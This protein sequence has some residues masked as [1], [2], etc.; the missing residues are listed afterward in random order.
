MPSASVKNPNC[1]SRNRQRALRSKARKHT[2]Q[3]A[4]SARLPD[5]VAKADTKRGARTGLLPT[6]GP[7][8]PLSSKKARK[9]EKQMA[10]AIRRKREEEERQSQVEMKDAEEKSSKKQLKTERNAAVEA[11]EKMEIS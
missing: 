6:S 1:I 8:K 5:R 4:A 3:A 10:H 9:L 11:L 7:N 2:L